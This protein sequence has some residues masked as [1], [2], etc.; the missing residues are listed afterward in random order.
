[1]DEDGVG[2]RGGRGAKFREKVF[3]FFWF[4]E[5]LTTRSFFLILFII[6]GPPK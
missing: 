2:R 4:C 1:M 6:V 5:A 3:F